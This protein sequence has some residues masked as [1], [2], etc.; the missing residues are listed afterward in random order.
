MF[1]FYEDFRRVLLILGAVT[2]GL[3]VVITFKIGAIIADQVQKTLAALEHVAAGDLTTR[4][5]H[6]VARRILPL[7]TH[8]TPPFKLQPTRWTHWL[9]E[10]V[11]RACCSTPSSK[12]SLPSTKRA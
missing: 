1:G 9:F 6:R 2:I 5:E 11:T 12:A 3:S 10:I 4:L 7:Q 8:S